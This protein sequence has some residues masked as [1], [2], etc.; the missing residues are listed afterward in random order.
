MMPGSGTPSASGCTGIR[1][2][3]PEVSLP[4][5]AALRRREM[6]NLRLAILRVAISNRERS[7]IM[8]SALL[9]SDLT[10]CKTRAKRQGTQNHCIP[11]PCT[12][13][14]AKD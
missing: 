14:V 3:L 6:L 7:Q 1:A 8:L 2:R 9:L 10:N 13:H 12:T 5:F 11:K 4:A